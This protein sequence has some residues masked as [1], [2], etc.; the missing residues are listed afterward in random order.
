M[1]VGFVIGLV[2]GITIIK[3]IEKKDRQPE[4]RQESNQIK[5]IPINTD[6]IKIMKFNAYMKL[7]ESQREGMERIETLKKAE[8]IANEIGDGTGLI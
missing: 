6:K 5:L 1:E 4:W 3:A 7:A 2:M 8:K